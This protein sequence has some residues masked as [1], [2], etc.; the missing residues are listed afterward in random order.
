MFYEFECDGCKTRTERQ[1]RMGEAPKA[2]KCDRCGGRAN[3]VF[4]TFALSIDG[5]IN[6]T[7]TFGE[8]MRKRNDKAAHRMKGKSA[9]VRLVAHDHGNGDVRGV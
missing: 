5:S 4:S 6:R 2:V 3:R 8:S 1:F 9:P 7:S